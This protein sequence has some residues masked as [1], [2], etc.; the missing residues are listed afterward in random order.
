M[1]VTAL[2]RNEKVYS[3]LESTYGTPAS[4]AAAANAARILGSTFNKTMDRAPREDRRNTRSLLERIE[5]RSSVDWSLEGYLLSGNAAGTP[6]DGWDDI[7]ECLFGTETING[8]TS[9]VYSLAKEFSKSLTLH[10]AN[11]QAAAEA[12]YGYMI[13]GAVPQTATFSLSGQDEAKISVA[14]FGADLLSAGVD[15]ISTDDGDDIVLAGTNA[16]RMFDVSQYIDIVGGATG[17]QILSINHS[18]NTLTVD[19]HTPGSPAAVIIPSAVALGQTF[20][21]ASP[22]S[23]ILGSASL[24]STAFMIIAAEIVLDNAP[25]PH[26]DKYGSRITSDFHLSN[27]SVTGSITFRV[28]DASYIDLARSAFNLQRDL[29]LVAGTAAGS[30]ATFDLNTVNFDFTSANVSGAEDIQVT[31]PFVALGSSGEDELTLTFT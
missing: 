31:V 6:P 1:T 24:D 20:T 4:N 27:R 13:T 11:G 28:D 12:V 9:V 21:S 19:N 16:S 8:G 22:I 25:Q 17:L 15:A 5:R 18:T 14:G 26:N 23:G 29:Q 7:L 10:R 3:V 2:G 30:I